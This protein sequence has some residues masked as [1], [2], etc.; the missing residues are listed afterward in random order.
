MNMQRKR[1]SG[2]SLTEVLMAAG[3]LAMGFMMVLTLFPLGLKLT[4]KQT[5]ATIGT[6][7]A[8]EAFINASLLMQSGEAT[9]AV[10]AKYKDF[11]Q[12]FGVDK[13]DPS[14]FIYP[15]ASDVLDEDK[16]YSTTVLLGNAN[17]DYAEAIVFACRRIGVEARFPIDS[18]NPAILG[19]RPVALSVNV[20]AS[21][22]LLTF[23]DGWP[24]SSYICFESEIVSD[25]DG[26]IY[27]VVEVMPTDGQVRV[28]RA[29]TGIVGKIW[30]VPP[31]VGAGRSAA[32][33]VS[34]QNIRIK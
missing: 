4:A 34:R 25:N 24:I 29:L 5:E 13:Y 31:A 28:D 27:K 16:K 11:D 33:G 3:I 19:D 21:D 7:A 18:D 12:I 32:V 14:L 15:T 9:G 2:F 20:T 8:R 30:F 10:A 17:G 22:D 23:D 6:L 26:Q 1:N